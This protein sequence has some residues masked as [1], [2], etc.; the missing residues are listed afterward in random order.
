MKVYYA[1]NGAWPTT[2]AQLASSGLNANDLISKH[3]AT[4]SGGSY[5]I[6]SPGPSYV[7]TATASSGASGTVTLN[8]QGI[9]AGTGDFAQVHN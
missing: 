1:E 7:L 6:T 9:L 5:T 4:A 2:I 8:Y 3:F